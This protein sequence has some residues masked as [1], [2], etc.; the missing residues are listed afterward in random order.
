MSYLHII[1]AW[2]LFIILIASY[3][4]AKVCIKRNLVSTE[5]DFISTIIR[6]KSK[7]L[8]NENVNMSINTYL[9]LMSITP[10]LTGTV[11]FLLS[12]NMLFSIIVATASFL[13]PEGILFFL[14]QKANRNFEECYAKSLENLASSLRA[15]L[16]MS[17]AIQEVANN[18]FIYEPIRERYRALYSDIQM[19][20]SITEAFNR[21]AETTNSKDAKDV[22]IAIDVQNEVGG[23][24]ADIIL[25][26]SKDIHDRIMLRKEIKSMFAGTTSMVY[27]MDFFPILIVLFVCITNKQYA[28]FYLNSFSHM[29]ILVVIILLFVTGSFINH[30]K[31]RKIYKGASNYGK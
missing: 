23:Y 22:A 8:S 25:S 1:A 14:R 10:I 31:I 7:T 15:G 2:V 28:E 26:I 13:T 3:L 30:A 17:Q 27:L 20:I 16:S 29:V 18:K 19:G 21:F 11:T 4:I 24:E 12:Y 9:L 6:K 5:I